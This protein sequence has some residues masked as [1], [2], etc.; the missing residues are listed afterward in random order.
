MMPTGKAW[1]TTI[2]TGV[3]SLLAAMFLLA[4]CRTATTVETGISVPPAQFSEAKAREILAVAVRQECL[5]STIGISGLASALRIVERA[6]A[7]QS[8]EDWEFS[9]QGK[10]AVVSL[11]GHVSGG[12]LRD[13]TS[14]C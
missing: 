6:P 9:F 8:S 2:R 12:L 13:L 7:I 11:S 4:A 5:K 3:L 10:S 14:L 1:T